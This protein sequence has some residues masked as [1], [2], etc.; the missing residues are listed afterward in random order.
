MSQRVARPLA[1]FYRLRFAVTGMSMLSAVLLPWLVYTATG[2]IGAAGLVMLLEALVR[3]LM[4]LYGGQVAHALGGR[5]AFALAQASCTA[6]FVLFAG[7]LATYHAS[8]GLAFV[9]LVGAL[10]AMQSGITL[11]N[12]VTESCTVAFVQAGRDEVPARVR[13]VDLAATAC[14]LPLGGW[15]VLAFGA[16]GALIALGAVLALGA[17]I[18]T[19]R[20]GAVFDAADSATPAR[21]SLVDG[22]VWRWLAHCRAAQL[23]TLFLLVVSVPVTMLFGALPFLLAGKLP[24]GLPAW[25]QPTD[26]L[27]LT[28]YKALEAAT[29]AA[30][31]FLW[32]RLAGSRAGTAATFALAAYLAALIALTHAATALGV[33]LAALALAAAFSPLL[34]YVRQQRAGVV[35]RGD[36]QR[37]SGVLVALDSLAY[38]AGALV[39]Q[40]TGFASATLGVIALVA[41]LLFAAM[42]L[43]ARARAPQPAGARVVLPPLAEKLAVYRRY[44]ADQRAYI[45]TRLADAVPRL[46]LVKR[47]SPPPTFL[48]PLAVSPVAAVKP[49]GVGLTPLV[50]PRALYDA[51]FATARVAAHSEEIAAT[52]RPLDEVRADAAA[53]GWS[54]RVLAHLLPA[55]Q[56]ELES[57]LEASFHRL[58]VDLL[59][60]PCDGAAAPGTREDGG[61]AAHHGTGALTARFAP[62][63]VNNGG[64]QGHWIGSAV[65]DVLLA[66]HGLEGRAVFDRPHALIVDVYDAFNAWLR[67]R[68]G[69]SRFRR[70][71]PSGHAPLA[72]VSGPYPGRLVNDIEGPRIAGFVHERYGVAAGY[73]VGLDALELADSV[74]LGERRMHFVRRRDDPAGERYVMWSELYVTESMGYFEDALR[75]EDA[76][77]RRLARAVLHGRV[78]GISAWPGRELIENDKGHLVEKAQ[79][80]VR[81]ARLGL[82]AGEAALLE[83]ASPDAFALTPAQAALVAEAREAWVLKGRFGC[84]GSAV[85]VGARA[86]WPTQQLPAVETDA[87]GR[88]SVRMHA[89]ANLAAAAGVA[90]ALDAE[91]R[92][93]AVSW[94]RLW[95][96]LVAFAARSPGYYVAQ[97]FV[98]PEPFHAMIYDGRRIDE[99][100]AT[101]DFAAAYTLGWSRGK[102][103]MQPAGTLCRA[104]PHGHPHTN[105]TTRGALLPVMSEDEFD[106]LYLALGLDRY[107]A[108]AK[109]AVPVP[110]TAPAAPGVTA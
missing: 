47:A 52:K 16:P 104:V 36:R 85:I 101:T 38:V 67:E 46:G 26:V 79:A 43:A 60:R 35:P 75:G 95:P 82:S 39:V 89:I 8:L 76:A 59:L 93:D 10:L 109:P 53:Q 17:A 83:D 86:S 77:T 84:G 110:E 23:Q 15:L 94:Q 45:E 9:V 48:T 55:S 54:T 69:R 57:R 106:R 99:F 44:L 14:A 19:Q 81:A 7:V 72:F 34:V 21:F 68:L 27:F 11:G 107:V 61:A 97:A 22:A 49:I 24:A 18:A 30:V 71:F 80:R 20:M 51:G 56:R 91:G 42:M 78:L 13:S 108:P 40:L 31:V 103:R 37:V 92:I 29:A 90:L 5:R 65:N 32:S 87:L 70:L 41:T 50:L 58:R 25:V 74:T 64:S 33:A 12:V 2:R 73:F 66:A 1:P 100:A 3:L 88:R 98:Q 28:H 96:A 62:L 105:V 63:E 6:G 102:P 4:S